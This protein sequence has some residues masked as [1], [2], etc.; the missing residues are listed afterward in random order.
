MGLPACLKE[1]DEL[2]EQLLGLLQFESERPA[3]REVI[4]ECVPQRGRTA[5]PG[6]GRA[7]FRS[8]AR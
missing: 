1:G 8:A 6:Q 5:P 2:R 7:I 3:D 4:E